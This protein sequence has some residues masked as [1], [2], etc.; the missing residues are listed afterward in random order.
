MNYSKFEIVTFE[1]SAM[2]SHFHPSDTS[3]T[4]SF[5]PTV[6]VRPSGYPASPHTVSQK[7]LSKKHIGRRLPFLGPSKSA[8]R[9][10]FMR[11]PL[12][13][14][15]PFAT[16]SNFLADRV[17]CALL[18]ISRVE[19]ARIYLPLPAKACSLP[20][21]RYVFRRRRLSSCR[22][23]ASSITLAGERR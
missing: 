13:S 1:F 23:G 18:H 17:V 9:F 10:I 5:Q 6:P 16:V 2:N 14:P 22:D 20:R 21:A 11:H 19:E 8:A 4:L 3:V 7:I 15:S 12:L